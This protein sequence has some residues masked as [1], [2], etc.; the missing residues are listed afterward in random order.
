MGLVLSLCRQSFQKVP[1][2]NEEQPRASFRSDEHFQPAKDN[3]SSSQLFGA[4]VFGHSQPELL[5]D[6]EK[7]QQHRQVQRAQ[8]GNQ[9]DVGVQT[10]QNHR[11]CCSREVDGLRLIQSAGKI[12][13]HRCEHKYHGICSIMHAIC[14]GDQADT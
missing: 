3:I 6:P 2:T 4:P 1:V 10:H 14:I 8:L 5:I 13:K 7:A 9:S 12:I 11:S